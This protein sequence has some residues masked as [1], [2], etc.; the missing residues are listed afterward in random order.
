M[1]PSYPSTIA[2]T[3]SIG[4][5]ALATLLLAPLAQPDALRRA[6]SKSVK[7]LN[8]LEKSLL[9]ASGKLRQSEPDES[10]LAMFPLASSLAAFVGHLLSL[11]LLKM[12]TEDQTVSQRSVSPTR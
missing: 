11:P 2:S 5:D 10:M 3:L 9:A 8:V 7:S 6:S 12:S 4:L 1:L